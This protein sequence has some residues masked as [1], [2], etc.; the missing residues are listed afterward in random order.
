MIIFP[1][2][3]GVII[4]FLL[5]TVFAAAMMVKG[6][7]M[8]S[9]LKKYTSLST[10]PDPTGDEDSH[11]L[12]TGLPRSKVQKNFVI[13]SGRPVPSHVVDQVLHASR[14]GTF[15]C[16]PRPLRDAVKSAIRDGGG[17]CAF[18]DEQSEM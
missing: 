14:P 17:A 2:V 8:C 7:G 5:V 12:N 16:G 4:L 9:R 18:Y 3:Y 6:F 13:A 10:I 11:D 15:F 1:R